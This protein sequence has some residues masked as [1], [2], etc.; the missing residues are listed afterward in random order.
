M[1]D[2][3]VSG[4]EQSLRLAARKHDLTIVRVEDPLEADLPAVGLLQVE[5]AETGRQWLIDTG[6]RAARVL[7]RKQA[8]QRREELAKLARGAALDLIEVSTDGDH[9]DALVRFFQR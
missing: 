2:F 5:D 8:E 3:L 6:Y 9:L 7:Y 4:Y 1:S